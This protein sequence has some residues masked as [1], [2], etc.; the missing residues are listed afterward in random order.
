[1]FEFVRTNTKLIQFI[2]AL[3]TV[4]FAFWGIDS[5]VRGADHSRDIATVAGQPITQNEFTQAL[6]RQQD[7]MRQ[8]FG[9]GY[10]ANRFD[11]P[12]SRLTLVNGLV[13][14]RLVM[15]EAARGNLTLTDDDLRTYLTAIPSFQDNGKFSPERYEQVV[16]SQSMTKPEFESAVRGDLVLRQLTDTI[17]NTEIPSKTVI[18][19]WQQINEQEREVSEVVFQPAQFLK[20][21]QITPEAIKQY[22][23]ANSKTFE[24]P[25]TVT[26][27]YLVLSLDT[28]GAQTQPTEDDLKAWYDAHW[29]QFVTP[30][31]RQASH[32]LV[33][34]PKTATE[35][36]RAAAK[37]KA[38]GL[39]A[40]VKKNPA[41]FAELAKKNSDDPGSAAKGGDLGLFNR[42]MMVKPFDDAVFA[43]KQGEISGIV[44][45]DF[46]YHIIKLTDVKA[47]DRKSLAEVHAQAEAEVRK[48]LA[49]KKFAEAAEGF[50]NMVYEQADS[51]QPAADKFKLQIQRTG[52]FSKR[53]APTAVPALNNQKLLD[54][55]FSDDAIKN[56]RNTEA[57]E[58]SPNTLVS[59]RVVQSNPAHLRTLGEVEPTIRLILQTKEASLQAHARAA[60]AQ[61]ELAK[62]GDAA[63][64]ANADLKWSAPKTVSR[65]TPL[66]LKPD[67][68]KAVFAT[69]VS[70]LPA[71]AIADAGEAAYALYRISAVNQPQVFLADKRKKREDELAASLTRGDFDGYLA[72]LR[73]KTKVTVNKDALAR[74]DQ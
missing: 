33:A 73:A 5:Y 70:K 4:P 7:Q 48:Q 68:I 43:M 64:A 32:I 66:D 8:M 57:V 6:Q 39:L 56:K 63:A 14:R 31:Q 71:Y 50:G 13:D 38:E 74:K 60:I 51:L 30:E 26:A 59:A 22:Y 21:V 42:G 34:V 3:I 40:Q 49:Q 44:E 55:L 28:L 67:E 19:R 24:A 12:E 18:S 65:Q 29:T 36:E 62:G 20:Q 72:A 58:T 10:D 52:E 17:E 9:R 53:D 45:S 35:A 61:K 37:A 41:S 47:P 16:K 2:L 15:G 27:Q 11:T 54:A 23:E 46:G 69:D 25:Q 1:M